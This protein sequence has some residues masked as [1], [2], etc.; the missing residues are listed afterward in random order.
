MKIRIDILRDNPLNQKIYGDDDEKQFNELVEKIK[1]SGWIKAILITNDYLIISGH[2]RVKAARLLGFDSIECEIVTSDP[3]KQVE[4][5]LNENAY[6]LKSNTQLLREAEMYFDIEQKKA[7][8]RELAG[9]APEVNLPQGRTTEIVAERIGMSESSYKKGRKILNR[10][11]E[12]VD[13]N[14][15]WIL[16]CRTDQSIDAGSKLAEK[17]IGFIQEVIEKTGGDKDKIPSAIREVEQE[18]RKLKSH[19]P[20]GKYKVLYCDLTNN[21]SENLSKLPISEIGEAD[22]VLFLWTTP[23]NLEQVL[24]LIN[25]W[26][27]HYKTCMIWYKDVF[28]ISDKVEILTISTK[29]NPPMISKSDEP[30]AKTEKP[31]LVREIIS[32]S[33]TGT[34]IE[35]TFIDTN[36]DGWTL[37]S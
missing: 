26:G 1:M 33:Y 21:P 20:P 17:P 18:E 25:L 10:I 14:I 9:V 19:L 13:P 32:A 5:F 24:S 11:D 3:D 30:D 7:H 6:R 31:E 2:R 22:S 4:I 34:K 28:E 29:G 8:Q 27:F 23:R 12:E 16:E 15:E 36:I 37:W 35:L